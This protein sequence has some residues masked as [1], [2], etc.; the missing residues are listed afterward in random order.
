MVRLSYCTSIDADQDTVV[1]QVGSLRDG[2]IDQRTCDPLVPSANGSQARTGTCNSCPVY[3]TPAASIAS[4]I[5]PDYYNSTMTGGAPLRPI[6][7]IMKS[8]H[9]L[10]VFLI[11]LSHGLIATFSFAVRQDS[12]RGA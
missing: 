12:D 11:N 9:L 2:A 6:A 1:R 3:D 8:S 7:I 5:D 4:A 10:C